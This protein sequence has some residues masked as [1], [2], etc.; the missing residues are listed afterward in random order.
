MRTLLPDHQGK[1]VKASDRHLLLAW[2]L[3]IILSLIWGSS[4]I[5]IKKGL[6]SFNAGEVGNLRIFS[7]GIFLLPLAVANLKSVNTRSEWLVIFVVGLFGSLVPA[8]LYAKAQTQLSSSLTGIL[9][10]LTPL[11][12]L[13]IGALFFKRPVTKRIGLGLLVG[14]IGTI[15]L[16]VGGARANLGGINLYVFLV[17]GATLL[18]GLNLNLIKTYL[19][20]LR[21]VGI[22]SIS[23]LMALPIS[24]YYLFYDGSFLEK[25][26]TVP[27]AYW[28][29]AYVMV[30]GIA[31][32]ALALILF[33]R[34]VQLKDPV[35]AS[36]VTYLIPVV[37]II[38]GVI[39]EE[40]LL[41]GHY[42][43]IFIIVV[44]IYIANYSS[45]PPKNKTFPR[46]SKKIINK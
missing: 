36:S 14:F 46:L 15:V 9:N 13:L 32:T 4:F 20:K 33:N 42:L 18:Y 21:A 17:I 24:G 26:Q 37:V 39:D 22:T 34:L 5:L 1:H 6:V 19:S 28:S 3:L 38:W 45:K 11:M 29:L 25:L 31:G 35:F 8:L 40:V 16:I 7:A 23:L 10:S 44:G 12:T 30:L 2:F 41:L 43:G 27:G